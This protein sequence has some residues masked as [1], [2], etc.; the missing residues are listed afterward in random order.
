MFKT[1][2]IIALILI[3]SFQ[4]VA[5]K[6]SAVSEVPEKLL[7]AFKLEKS[8]HFDEYLESKGMSRERV[9]HSENANLGVNWFLRKIIALSSVTYVF[10]K[11]SKP[12]TY[13]TKLLSLKKN[14]IFPDWKLD[15]TFEAEGM[16][17]TMHKVRDL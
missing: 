5:M 12:G 1:L 8:E 10:E 14:L 17:G 4:I 3:A 6:D 15:E 16:D 7:G 13:T 9:S 2:S 11:G